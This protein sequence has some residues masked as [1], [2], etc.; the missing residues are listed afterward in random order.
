MNAS[1]AWPPGNSEMAAQ[2]RDFDWGTT[3]LGVPAGWPQSLRTVIDLLL[4][5]PLPMAVLWGPD[6][7]QFHNDSYSRLP[8]RQHPGA[9]GQPVRLLS[10]D[11]WDVDAPVYER[12]RAG[13]E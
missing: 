11:T 8:G 13:V 10:A 5:H 3:P 12:V 2:I 6:L 9:L 1:A 7:I 4:A